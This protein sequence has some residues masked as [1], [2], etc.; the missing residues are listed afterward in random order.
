MDESQFWSAPDLPDEE[1]KAIL[2]SNNPATNVVRDLERRDTSICGDSTF[3]M[4]TGTYSA[5]VDDCYRLVSR[6]RD[7]NRMYTVPMT[8]G[9]HR[10]V[11]DGSCLFGIR[12]DSNRPINYV[13]SDNAADLTMDSI[14]RFADGNT[15]ATIAVKAKGRM[16]CFENREVIWGLTYV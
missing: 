7:L 4:G 13:G 16:P 10:L 15:D 6:L 11:S 3:Y 9:W 12:N 8:K 2:Q 5:N 14:R 1:A